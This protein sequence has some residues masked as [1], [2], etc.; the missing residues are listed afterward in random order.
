ML[1]ATTRS[2]AKCF[3]PSPP[4]YGAHNMMQ[5][6]IRLLPALLVS[7]NLAAQ[8]ATRSPSRS[9]PRPSALSPRPTGFIKE[10][11]TMWTFDAPPLEYWR[12]TYNFSPDQQWLDHVRLSAVRIPGC[13]ASLV[14][15]NGLVMT[16]HHCG[17]S[18]TAS[19]SPADTNY[20]DVGFAAR[21]SSD[22]KKCAGMY[23]DQLQS[24]QDVTDRIHRAVTASTAAKQV[25]QRNA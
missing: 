25:E 10:F 18:C 1:Y 12:T 15:A 14:S 21:N 7:G 3:S 19:A 9:S 20:V 24:I 4:K 17:R 6:I 16:N 22:E 8:A 23:A 13:S 11:G 2:F 5:R